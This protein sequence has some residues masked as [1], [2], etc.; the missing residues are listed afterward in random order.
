MPQTNSNAVLNRLLVILHRS[1]P[2]YLADAAPWKHLGDEAAANVLGHLVADYRMYA[3]RIV[4]LLLERRQRLEFG[5]F[6]MVFTD[7]HDLAL[8]YLVGELIYYQQ[9]DIAAIQQ[10]IAELKTDAVGQAL[11]EEVLGNARGHLESLQELLK[12][13]AAA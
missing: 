2:M 13:P 12:R 1:L 3:G 7:T 11:A 8:D 4:N 6:P 10:C 5:D 9:Q